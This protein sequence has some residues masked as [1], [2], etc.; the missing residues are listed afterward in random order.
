MIYVDAVGYFASALVFSTFYTKTMIPLRCIAIGSNF[1][2]IAYGFFGDIYPV[3]ILHVLM[4]PLNT[5]RL[6]QMRRLIRQVRE[7]AGAGLSMEC[8]LPYMTKRHAREGEVLFKKGENAQEV[9][10]IVEGRVLLTEINV[11]LGKGDML[12]E[13]GV[14]SPY[15]KRTC[16]AVCLTD[17]EFSSITDDKMWQL[18]YQNPQ[19]GA[20]LIKLIIHRFVDNESHI[21]TL[22]ASNSGEGPQ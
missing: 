21:Q 8:L 17:L 11:S 14:F 2:F 5:V 18:F 22:L 20:H 13:I 16:T 4:L 10:F 12:G 9:F 3:L 1:V 7:A 15:A 6:L 19:F